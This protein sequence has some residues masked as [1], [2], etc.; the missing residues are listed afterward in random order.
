MDLSPGRLRS[1]PVQ[2]VEIDDGVVL[3]RGC[4]ETCV[5]GTGAVETVRRLLQATSGGGMDAAAVRDLF[6]AGEH[7]D[8]DALIEHLRRRG[9]LVSDSVDSSDARSFETSADVFYWH[10]GAREADAARTLAERRV[11]VVGLNGI[12]RQLARSLASCGAPSVS[13]VDDPLLRNPDLFGDDGMPNP[14]VWSSGSAPRIVDGSE[15]DPERLDCLVATSE[16][17]ASS[18]VARWNEFCVLHKRPFLPVVLKDLVGSIGP[19]VIPGETAC[20]ECA[21]MRQRAHHPD[22]GLRHAIEAAAG[23]GGP[24]GFLPPM[25]SMLADMAAIELI[26]FFCLGALPSRVGTLIEVSVLARQMTPRPVLRLPRCPVCTPIDERP[27]LTPVHVPAMA[28]VRGD[29]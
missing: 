9:L 27:D 8:L 6:P 15:I 21:R 18:I 13:L 12:T 4:V 19:L 11:V 25:S 23:Q 10:F 3:K 20:Y 24:A 29:G 14:E 1:L 2:V 16:F 22:P 7:D 17:G 26:R 5:R 28:G